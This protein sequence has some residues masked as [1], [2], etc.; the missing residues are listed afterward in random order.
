[1]RPVL[2]RYG[3]GRVSPAWESIPPLWLVFLMLAEPWHSVTVTEVGAFFFDLLDL[4]RLLRLHQAAQLSMTLV[5]PGSCGDC[6]RCHE[7]QPTLV[8]THAG[9][10]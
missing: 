2:V 10:A 9:N 5:F 6:R 1:M 8:F 7:W 4:Q 3:P